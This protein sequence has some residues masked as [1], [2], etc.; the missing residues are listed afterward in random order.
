MNNKI[1][2]ARNIRIGA[3]SLRQLATTEADAARAAEMLRIAREMDE[4]AAALEVSVANA[5]VPKKE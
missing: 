4:H 5:A 3:E 2:A 1:I